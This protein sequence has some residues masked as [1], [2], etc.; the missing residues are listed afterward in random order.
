VAWRDLLERVRTHRRTRDR[1]DGF[2]DARG[3]DVLATVGASFC[4]AEID[5][6]T[7]GGTGV[8]D[9]EVFLVRDARNLHDANA[10][11]VQ[12]RDGRRLAYLDQQHAA[13]YAPALDH[14]GADALV[15]AVASR[16]SRG[17][18]W[19]ITIRY[20]RAL[21]DEL[22]AQAELGVGASDAGVE[23]NTPPATP[24]VIERRSA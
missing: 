15:T 2:F 20:D 16:R 11:V 23:P 12:A 17:H 5:A 19:A 24:P 14:L 3:D 1:A 18:H 9:L 8:L 22:R 4:R 7:G 13:A 21:L 6:V 10:V